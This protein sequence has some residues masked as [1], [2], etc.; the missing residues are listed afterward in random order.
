VVLKFNYN[1]I[2]FKNI[3]YD[4]IKLRHLKYVIKMTLQFF[5]IFKSPPQQ[6]PGCASE[7]DFRFFHLYPKLTTKKKWWRYFWMI[8]EVV[9]LF[10][11]L[12]LG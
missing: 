9:L 1:V 10:L 11:W 3:N 7:C 8:S 12:L 4:V 5:S 2:K 6:N